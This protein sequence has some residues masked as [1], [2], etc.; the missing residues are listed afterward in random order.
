MMFSKWKVSNIFRERGNVYEIR[1]TKNKM[2][3]HFRLCI[4]HADIIFLWVNRA[5]PCFSSFIYW[6][7]YAIFIS[8][9]CATWSPYINFLYTDSHK[10]KA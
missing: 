3:F 6:H 8:L 1:R 2:S 9:V 7:F 5:G 10:V 4:F